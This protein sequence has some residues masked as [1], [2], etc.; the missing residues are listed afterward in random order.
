MDSDGRLGREALGVLRATLPDAERLSFVEADV[1]AAEEPP[2]QP[3]D[4]VDARLLLSHLRDP[5]AMLR[6]LAVRTRPGGVL[7]VQDYDV[8]V[9]DIWPSLAT[10]GE[11]ERVIGGV[12]EKT[13][14]DLRF[15]RKLPLHFVAAGLGEPDG[16]DVVG[17]PAPTAEISWLYEGVYRSVLPAALRLGVTTEAASQAFLAEIATVTADRA[18]VGLTPLLIS[19][20]NHPAAEGTATTL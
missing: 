4:L 15:G 1:E 10:W 8:P 13:G 18:H 16:A 7:V 20:W 2:G 3:F 12:Y 11:F 9:V 5:V 6:K 14:R 19:A 17:V